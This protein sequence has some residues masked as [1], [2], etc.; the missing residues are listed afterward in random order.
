[1][2][3]RVVE[4]KDE[5]KKLILEIAG[6]SETLTHLLREKLWEFKE[7]KEAAHIREHPLLAEPKILVHVRRGRA[8]TALSEATRKLIAEVR[9][10]RRLFERALKQA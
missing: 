7:V 2:E 6:E 4:E 9:Q 5:K 1:M 8:R 10:L 3:L